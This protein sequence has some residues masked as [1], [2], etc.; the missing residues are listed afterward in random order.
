MLKRIQVLEDGRVPAKEARSW[1]LGRRTKEEEPQAISIRGFQTS[2]KLKVFF[3][4]N[5][6]VE[7]RE[8]RGVAGQR[9]VT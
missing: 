6:V 4:A 8:R 1:R 7:S 2:L 5:R 3:G 9:S